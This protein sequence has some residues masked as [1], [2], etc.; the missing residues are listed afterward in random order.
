MTMTEGK[1]RQI[2]RMIK[3]INKHVTRLKRIRF[4]PYRLDGIE[5]GKFKKIRR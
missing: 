2:R 1:N 4:G 3:A 5:V